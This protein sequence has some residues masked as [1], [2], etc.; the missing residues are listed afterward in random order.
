M[1]SAP[2]LAAA[3]NAML[4]ALGQPVLSEER[5]A[6]AV[7][8]GVDKLVERTLAESAGSKPDGATLESASSLFREF[9]AQSVFDASVVYP[10]V[11]EGLEA[12]AS[13][14]LPLACVTNKHSRFT[15]ALLEKAG[16]A[17]WLTLV[18]CAD[19]PEQRKPAPYL[20]LQACRGLAIE[21]AELLFVGDSALDVAAA[22]AAGCPVV[23][24]SYGY[25]RGR[26][27]AEAGADAVI[28]GI[29]RLAEMRAPSADAGG[30]RAV[31]T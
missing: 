26:P 4:A 28:A 7:G 31:P 6:A 3:A 23:L 29:D 13:R 17:R 19:S 18:L 14:G 15:T 16:L 9:Y 27:A 11:R 21:P 12:L 24:V 8:D 2:D 5:V 22:R 25:N 20:L 30:R 10:G 1:D